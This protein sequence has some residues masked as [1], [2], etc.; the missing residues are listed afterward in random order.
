MHGLEI[1]KRINDKC[2]DDKSEQET[3]TELLK[4]SSVDV[5]LRTMQIPSQKE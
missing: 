3:V 4:A 2:T 5:D 1:I